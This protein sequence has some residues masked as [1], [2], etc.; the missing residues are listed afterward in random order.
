MDEVSHTN[1]D[2]KVVILESIHADA[3]RLFKENGFTRLSV[4][5]K[6]LE[7]KELQEQIRDAHIV[8]IRSRTRIDETLFAEC[9]NLMAVGCYCIGTNQVEL[10]A[11]MLRG[12][13]V[14]NDPHSN[15]RSVAEMV[16][17]L[18]IGLMRGLF[19][20]NLATH[21][22]E[23]KKSA[24]GAHEVR[25][26]TLGIVGYGHIGSQVAVLAEALG[27][28]VFY[29]DIETRLSIGNS[30]K[31]ASLEELL[32]ISDIV[33]LHVPETPLTKNMMNK[34]RLQL[35][36]KE[37]FLINTSRGSVVEIDELARMLKSGKLQGAALDVY[38]N[39]PTKNGLP[40]TS[41]LCNLENAVLTPHVGGATIEA[42]ANIA[43]VLT[44]KLMNFI[45][46]GSTEGAANFPVLSLAPNEESHRILHIHRNI[47]GML[48]QINRILA[49]R[50]INILAQ[51]LKTNE[52]VGYVVFDIDKEY[53]NDI[54]TPLK[55]IEGTI[56]ARILY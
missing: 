17:G 33:T 31:I 37:A 42:Q 46:R 53:E 11:G 7:G 2:I 32:K 25:G 14:F 1:E 24:H 23:W 29:Y 20:K 15:T 52:E 55:E 12:V 45:N 5:P 9:R 40:F 21:A 56:R 48:S 43:A 35:M 50:K 8:A 28:R 41:P 39:E 26:K 44:Q 16:I 30:V 47:P 34:K 27:M 13:P 51:Y 22:G 4:L 54:M 18:C 49:E 6:A 19:N 10:R 36:K 3:A 38:P